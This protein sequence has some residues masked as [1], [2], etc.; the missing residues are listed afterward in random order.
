MRRERFL[1]L[2]RG[3]VL[4]AA[5]DDFLLAVN[6]QHVTMFVHRGQ[7]ARMKPASAKRAVRL[8][9]LSP[10]A[11][12]DAVSPGQDL[13]DGLSVCRYIR[14][15]PV[16]YSNLDTGDCET[17]HRLPHVALTLFAI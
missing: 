3:N 1:N 13:A 4:T 8:L 17:C 15:L 16:H 14:S 6:N 10:V 12:H 2:Q 9:G 7:V 5:N 11:F